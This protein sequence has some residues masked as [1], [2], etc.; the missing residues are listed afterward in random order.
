M[1]LKQLTICFMVKVLEATVLDV[2]CDH[3]YIYTLL[4]IDRYSPCPAPILSEA[5]FWAVTGMGREGREVV[6]IVAKLWEK[7]CGGVGG[8]K[9]GLQNMMM[10]GK[11]HIDLYSLRRQGISGTILFEGGKHYS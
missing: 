4:L 3:L 8:S 6:P 9:G 7:R 5:V 2:H 11:E 1:K 10:E